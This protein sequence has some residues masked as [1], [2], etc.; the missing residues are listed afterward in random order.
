MVAV[1]IGWQE[2]GIALC[3]LSRYYR[4]LLI[5]QKMVARYGGKDSDV[6]GFPPCWFIVVLVALGG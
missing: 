1:D 6:I 3:G 2:G 4:Y 5:V